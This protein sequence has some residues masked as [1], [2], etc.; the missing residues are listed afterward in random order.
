MLFSALGHAKIT[1]D[2]VKI[3]V[4]VYQVGSQ[5]VMPVDE[6]WKI[7][8]AWSGFPVGSMT[9]SGKGNG[10]NPDAMLGVEIDGRT[11]AFIDLLWRYRLN[12]RGTILLHPFAPNQFIITENERRR[13]KVTTIEF[14]EGSVHSTKLKEGNLEE[15]RFESPNTYDIISAVFLMM[16][17]EY[18]VGRSYRI[19]ALTGTSRYLVSVE[20]EAREEIQVMDRIVEAYRLVIHTNDLTDP[21]DNEKHAGTYMWVSTAPPRRMLRAKATTKWGS[22]YGELVSIF[23]SRAPADA[24]VELFPFGPLPD[25]GERL[26]DRRAPRPGT[27]WRGKPRAR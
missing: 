13:E 25:A 16:H 15:F 18:E 5:E 11:N 9:I 23:D 6:T 27:P 2:A 22:I 7:D 26:R 12:A 10:E 19:D 14:A 3:D 8:F 21:K 24:P 17:L 20:V 1:P 4:P